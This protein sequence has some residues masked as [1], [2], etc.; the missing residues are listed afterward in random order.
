MPD[1]TIEAAR[2]HATAERTID[3]DVEPAHQLMRDLEEAG[4]DFQDIVS[5]QLVDE[6]VKSFAKSYDELIEAIGQKAQ[7][8]AGVS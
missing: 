6:G 2:D 3:R 4:V 7:R 5:N 1:A 8:L